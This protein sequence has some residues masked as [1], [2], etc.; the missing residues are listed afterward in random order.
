MRPQRS[1]W[2]N[3]LT[4][5]QTIVP[6]NELSVLSE[7]SKKDAFSRARSSQP[8]PIFDSKHLYGK[9]DGVTGSLVWDYTEVGGGAATYISNKSAVDLTCGTASGDHARKQSHRYLP[10]IP[11]LSNLIYM[12]GIMGNGETNCEKRIGQFNDENGLFFYEIDGTKGV[13]I[14]TSISGSVVNTEIDQAN[15]NV[16]PM[17]GNGPSSINIDWSKFQIFSIDYSWLGGARIRFSLFEQGRLLP[18]HVFDNANNNAAPFITTPTLPLTYEIKNTGVTTV[19]NTLESICC[20]LISE[21]GDVPSGET[22]VATMGGVPRTSIT[23]R[24][25]ILAVRP[26]ATFLGKTNRISIQFVSFDVSVLDQ[27]CY[28]EIMSITAPTTV[29]GTWSD[30][31]A[32]HSC[33][34]VSTDISVVAGGDQHLIDG[35]YVPAAK[36]GSFVSSLLRTFRDPTQY[37]TLNADGVTQDEYFVVFATATQNAKA[38]ATIRIQEVQ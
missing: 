8:F 4:G 2:F 19:T 36:D 33:V 27:P 32:N 1:N 22:Y 18:V 12:T 34:E 38:H 5:F 9:N 14:R 28:I 11:G 35:K 21:G 23:T 29:T 24:Q 30:L 26:K 10:Y 16:D 6:N 17:D 15:W 37:I 31:D 25:P 7:Y 20:T 13:A 3:D